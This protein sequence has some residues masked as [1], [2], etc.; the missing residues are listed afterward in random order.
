MSTVAVLGYAVEGTVSAEYFANKGDVVTVCD[1]D[2][3]VIIPEKFHQRKGADSFHNLHEFDIIIRSAGIH[4]QTI[5]DANPSHPEI[6]T[7]ITTSINEF[8]AACP[9]IQVIAVTGT[10]GKGTTCSLITEILRGAGKTVHFGGNIGIAPLELLSSVQ[11]DDWVVLELSSFQ[12]FDFHERI[13]TAVCLPVNEEHL[14]W[15]SDINDYHQAKANLFRYQQTE[16]LA[17]YDPHNEGSV[18]VSSVSPANK[19]AFDVP[20]IGAAPEHTEAAYVLEDTIYYQGTPI[21]ATDKVALPGRYNLENMC[22]AISAT[23]SVIDGNLEAIRHGLTTFT[24]LPM[25][26]ENIGQLNGATWYNDAYA[27]APEATIGALSVFTAPVVLITGGR[28]KYI[29]MEGLAEAITHS[30][31]RAVIV[32][33][34]L[35]DQIAEFLA[36]RHFEHVEHSTDIADAAS[37]AY[38]LARP[39]DIVLFSP[40]SAGT[41]RGEP[42][43]NAFRAMG[44]Q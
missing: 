42:F 44:G 2:E 5:L 38:A 29:S 23:W 12:L 30:S 11:P 33:G 37:K 31:V 20:A 17:V 14:D 8:V 13:R 39:G 7:R 32:N 15:H 36:D 9:T 1:N 43:T 16:D 3:S 28:N 4:P 34:D 21:I 22:A 27:T 41:L 25:H 40:G 6:A 26:L 24:G 10:K 19:I 18:R 35:S